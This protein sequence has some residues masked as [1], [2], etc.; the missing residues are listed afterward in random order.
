MRKVGLLGGAFNPPH[1]G[2]AKLAALALTHLGL[3]ELRF[4]PT[5]LSPH[6]ASPNGKE[7]VHGLTR[8]RLL[9]ELLP[10]CPEHCRLELLEVERGGVSYTA[11]TLETLHEREPNTA[12]ILI[13][14]GDQLS[15]F[16]HWRTFDRVMALASAAFSPRPGH[17]VV[18]PECLRPRLREA[19]SGAPGELLIL[20]PTEMD[21]AST[22]LRQDLREK[23]EV[24]GL[25]PE[26]LAAI[27]AEN[28]Y[29]E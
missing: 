14:G 3:D 24:E 2:H 11:D 17:E 13:L 15:E 1:L 25:V 21:V 6:K 18:V 5:A 26:V 12:W 16:H 29:R 9:Q 22:R 7:A 4:V 19:W 28:L 23:G 10:H 8:A 27:R 20:P